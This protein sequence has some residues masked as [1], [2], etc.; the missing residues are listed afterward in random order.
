MW[1]LGADGGG[2]KKITEAGEEK[3][4]KQRKERNVPWK[5]AHPK[6]KKKLKDGKIRSFLRLV[7]VD[8]LP[9]FPLK[10]PPRKKKESK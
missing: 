8:P 3:R 1:P 2:E 7:V 9:L 4:G 6:R 10:A 5:K